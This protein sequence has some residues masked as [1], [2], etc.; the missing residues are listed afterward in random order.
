MT[1]ITREQVIEA[2]NRIAADPELKVLVSAAHHIC[3]SARAL[4]L[5]Y[6]ET[7]GRVVNPFDER[8]IGA[9]RMLLMML[10]GEYI[11]DVNEDNH[12]TMFLP[13]HLVATA[14]LVYIAAGQGENWA[15]SIGS[16]SFISS[17]PPLLTMTGPD[18]VL[19]LVDNEQAGVDA[20]MKSLAEIVNQAAGEEGR[21]A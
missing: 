6:L 14:L 7:E 12:D 13:C 2:V 3:V 11:L 15:D 9:Q 18:G 8:E 5:E 19:R 1:A 21:A 4:Q 20:L 16:D 10:V 17:A